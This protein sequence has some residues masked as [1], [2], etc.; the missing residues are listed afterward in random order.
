[1]PVLIF[2][3]V[4]AD[5]LQSYDEEGW[6]LVPTADTLKAMEVILRHNVRAEDAFRKVFTEVRQGNHSRC[7]L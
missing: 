5:M 7:I 4:R 6:T 2:A 1:M 3:L